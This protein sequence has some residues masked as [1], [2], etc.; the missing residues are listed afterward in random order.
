MLYKV[1]YES[2]YRRDVEQVTVN[3]AYDA[4]ENDACNGNPQTE[5]LAESGAK[6]RNCRFIFADEHRLDHEEIVVEGDDGVDQ[7]YQH[8]DVDSDRALIDS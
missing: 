3:T 2:T 7:G 8:E 4:K 5:A 1:C 6:F